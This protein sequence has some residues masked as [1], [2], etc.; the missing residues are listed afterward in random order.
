MGLMGQASIEEN[1]QLCNIKKG[2]VSCE[3]TLG[4]CP[5]S[6]DVLS[7]SSEN[8][9]CCMNALPLRCPLFL[10]YLDL[11]FWLLSSS[12][13]PECLFGGNKHKQ[14]QH[15]LCSVGIDELVNMAT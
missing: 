11:L 3:E 5:V 7:Q 12:Q 9:L 15:F 1:E 14:W 8:P 4:L 6:S 2:R 10:A 13:Q